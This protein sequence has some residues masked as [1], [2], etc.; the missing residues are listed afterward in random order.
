MP[1][2]L[3]VGHGLDS[4]RLATGRRLVIAGVAVDAPRGAEAHSDGDVLL[5]ALCDALLSTANLGDIGQHFPDTDGLWLD[6]DSARMVEEVLAM[7]A[8]AGIGTIVNVAGVV[9][10]D[11]PK[12]APHRDAMSASLASLL[13]LP[14]ERVA[15]T[16][17]TSEGLA[18]DHV[19]ASVTLLV[20][21]GG[22][23]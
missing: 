9:I 17:K 6:F 22:E 11:A 3:L 8:R 4:H 15:L 2:T 18:P 10:L 12:L 21:G 1:P 13:G 7:L 19:Q 16:F 5:H 23:R 14:R 20:A